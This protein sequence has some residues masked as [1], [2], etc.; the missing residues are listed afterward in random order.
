MSIHLH[1]IIPLSLI[2]TV[3]IFAV[4]PLGYYGCYPQQADFLCILSG[5]LFLLIGSC[6]PIT[7]C[8]KIRQSR[9]FTMLGCYLWL[10]SVLIVTIVAANCSD[11][12]SLIVV[13]AVGA[14][15]VTFLYSSVCCLCFF[16]RKIGRIC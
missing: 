15:V 6:W 7:Y 10:L 9:N 4:T 1:S 5:V 2:V 13:I 16:S 8:W 3:L 12:L 11:P 14:V